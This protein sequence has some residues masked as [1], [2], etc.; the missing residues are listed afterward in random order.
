MGTDE[1]TNE[2]K[3]CACG[4][5]PE[6]LRIEGEVKAKFARVC[7]ECCG[8]W[9]VEFRNDYCPLDSEQSWDRA[10]QAWNSAPRPEPRVEREP[11]EWRIDW[12]L[13]GE[14]A[15]HTLKTPD[16]RDAFFA[17]MRQARLDCS[18]TPLYAAPPIER[19]PSDDEC[20]E[21]CRAFDEAPDMLISD[22]AGDDPQAFHGRQMWQAVREVMG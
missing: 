10:A 20:A 12:Q 21:I 4:H 9:I 17:G 5:V 7:G 16:D 2:L 8:E 19:E 18:V 1:M 6:G 14:S 22:D 13:S 15:S 3:P 11:V